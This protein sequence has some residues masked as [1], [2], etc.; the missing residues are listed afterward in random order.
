MIDRVLNCISFVRFIVSWEKAPAD[1][2]SKLKINTSLNLLSICRVCLM[3]KPN[4]TI[5]PVNC[6]FVL[7][8]VFREC[9]SSF[10]L[11]LFF[12]V[13]ITSPSCRYYSAV[14]PRFTS[15]LKKFPLNRV[16]YFYELRSLG[17]NRNSWFFISLL[18]RIFLH[19]Y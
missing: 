19:Y 14:L 11:S 4:S 5:L 1:A 12:Y 18:M 3:T 2:I 8:V 6:F 10:F 7:T 15:Q 16:K 13:T 17:R 9:A